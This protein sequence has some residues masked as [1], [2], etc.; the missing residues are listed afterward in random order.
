MN[1]GYGPLAYPFERGG[2]PAAQRCSIGLC[3]NALN[4]IAD[5]AL[6]AE[7]M[8][9]PFEIVASVDD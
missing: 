5:A 8:T 1:H 9:E 2:C 4:P 6:A 7:H 3:A